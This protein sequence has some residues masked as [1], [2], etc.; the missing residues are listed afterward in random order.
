LVVFLCF[1]FFFTDFPFFVSSSD[2]SL[3]EGSPLEFNDEEEEE[4][5]EDEEE[6]EE[7]KRFLG[8]VS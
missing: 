2:A 1:G 4:E 3:E 8:M 5:E 7:G 6:E